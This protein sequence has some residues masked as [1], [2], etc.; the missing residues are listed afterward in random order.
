MPESRRI[1]RAMNNSLLVA[2]SDVMFEEAG[3]L[4]DLRLEIPSNGSNFKLL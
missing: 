1:G 2:T 4:N 3:V